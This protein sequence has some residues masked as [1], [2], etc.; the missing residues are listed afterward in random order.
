[1]VQS[2]LSHVDRELPRRILKFMVLVIYSGK[3]V[4]YAIQIHSNSIEGLVFG[5]FEHNMLYAV[6]ALHLP[7][8][9]LCFFFGYFPSDASSCL[10]FCFIFLVSSSLTNL[11]D[12][13]LVGG[14]VKTTF[15]SSLL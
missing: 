3:A 6:L 7:Q 8:R 10:R 12:L 2:L 1:V 11:L 13:L 5:L 15:A 9:C 14:L 4:T